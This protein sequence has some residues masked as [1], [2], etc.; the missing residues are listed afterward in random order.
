LP[1]REIPCAA[2]WFAVEFAG[3]RLDLLRKAVPGL[4]QLAILGN[5][6]SHNAK[7][8]MEAVQKAARKLRIGTT[9]RDIRRTPQVASAINGVKGKA[10]ALYVCTDPFVTHHRVGIN[11][12]AAGAGLPTMHAFP[13]H[14][15]AGGL[16]SYGPD[17]RDLF[18]A[19]GDIV[20]QILHGAKPADIPVRL[21]TKHK[22]VFNQHTAK[23]LGVAVVKAP[24]HRAEAV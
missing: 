12:L 20:D 22:L 19:A 10:D 16:M 4:R 21:E 5:R 11:T 3:I 13:H 23:A 24:R 17:F 8:E 7:L 9:T 15:E 6:A 1:P 2:N 14:I 18:R